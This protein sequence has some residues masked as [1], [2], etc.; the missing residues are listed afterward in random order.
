[1]DLGMVIVLRLLCMW[2]IEYSRRRCDKHRATGQARKEKFS[3]M[4]TRNINY[5]AF[6]NVVTAEVDLLNFI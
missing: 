1:M 4:H 6:V 5:L 2:L 3:H